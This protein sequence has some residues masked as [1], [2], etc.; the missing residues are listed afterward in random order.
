MSLPG[1][2]SGVSDNRTG[3][4]PQRDFSDSPTGQRILERL[5][6][7]PRS[8]LSGKAG[9][10]SS[11]LSDAIERGIA[12][13]EVAV[14]IA[15]ALEVS[16]DWLLRGPPPSG[17]LEP[18]D[19][20][21]LRPADRSDW[22]TVPEYD[23]HDIT[24]E[25]LGAATS[26]TNIRKDWLYTTFRASSD[27]WLTRLLSDYPPA[28]LSEND[29]VICRDITRAQLAEGNLCLW[30]VAGRVV[31]GAFSTVPDALLAAN[32]ASG[33]DRLPGGG[34]FAAYLDPSLPG[35]TNALVVPPS[36]V[37]ND[38]PYHPIARILG[39]MLRPI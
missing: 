27:L 9:I 35:A 8:W 19:S 26:R 36:R 30:R 4:G 32:R 1:R 29:L 5:S 16:L 25:G 6:G 10:S 28:Q 2:K 23:L 14:K 22:V 11:T 18:V 20:G 15:E 33:S 7:R 12:K 37:E 39:V 3:R 17:G 38:G 24:D 31:I 34:A 13:T 21:V